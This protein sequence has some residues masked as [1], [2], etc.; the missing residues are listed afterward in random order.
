MFGVHNGFQGLID[1][2]MRPLEWNSV[3]G[4]SPMGGSELGTRR[5]EL[6]PR[7]IYAISRTI[8]QHD[9][10]GILVIGGWSAYKAAYRLHAERESYPAFDVPMVCLPASINN[11]MPGSALTIG[12]DTALNA[13]V[14]AVDKIKR[15]ASAQQ[16]CFVVD[17]MGRRCGYL[18][19]MAGLATGAERVYLHEEGVTLADLQEDLE[20]LVD[21]FKRGKRLGLAI[22]SEHAND[23][24]DARFMAKL[25]EEEG[26][27]LFD[28]R[29]AILGHMQQGGDPTSF[30]RVQASRLAADCIEFLIEQA[31]S[32]APAGAFIGVEAGQRGFHDLSA[33][34]KLGDFELQRPHEQWWMALRPVQRMLARA[35]ATANGG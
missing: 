27:D 23:V 3:A 16:R 18:A 29:V 12:A 31:A 13:I 4:W 7:D 2:D 32:D 33:L 5:N 34:P 10:E 26:G 25:F 1:G 30:D 21:G 22:R 8:E 24:Y 14:D 15:S 9:L 19:L 20:L 11:G 28:V 6:R 17:V 35:E